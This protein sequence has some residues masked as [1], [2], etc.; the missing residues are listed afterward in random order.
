MES[1]VNAKREHPGMDNTK[2]GKCFNPSMMLRGGAQRRHKTNQSFPLSRWSIRTP[3]KSAG[4]ISRAQIFKMT[5][6]ATTSPNSVHV[7]LGVLHAI[8]RR[9]TSTMP[10]R[11]GAAEIWLTA[12][13]NRSNELVGSADY[14]PRR[15]VR[16]SLRRFFLEWN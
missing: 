15:Y 11:D 12:D 5:T 8:L 4:P 1:S 3:R 7:L 14:A 6:Y 2:A 9:K 13:L 10:L 16:N